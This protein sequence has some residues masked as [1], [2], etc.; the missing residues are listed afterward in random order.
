M[1]T[2]VDATYKTT[3]IIPDEPD[4][5]LEII[6]DSNQLGKEPFKR[7]ADNQ[8]VKDIMIYAPELTQKK[9]D[10]VIHIISHAT[11]KP[12]YLFFMPIQGEYESLPEAHQRYAY[13]YISD[14]P[15]HRKYFPSNVYMSP[16]KKEEHK[17]K[18]LQQ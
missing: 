3:Y 5:T 13:N 8:K 16:I 4:G 6:M 2:I 7:R 17:K 14:D 12:T 10:E 18:L 15:A 11:I 9:F 1:G